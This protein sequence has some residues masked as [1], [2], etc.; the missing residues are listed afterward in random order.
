MVCQREAAV[1]GGPEPRQAGHRVL[2]TQLQRG[3]PDPLLGQARGK[4]H[5]KRD[6]N[7]RQLLERML[8]LYL[9]F[10]D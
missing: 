3:A 1:F 4:T 6:F 10:H 8:V 2:H 9:Q 5:A 7:A